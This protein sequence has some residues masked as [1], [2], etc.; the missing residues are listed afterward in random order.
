ME[1]VVA[2]GLA[3]GLKPELPMKNENLGESFIPL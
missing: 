2:N 3:I 1:I